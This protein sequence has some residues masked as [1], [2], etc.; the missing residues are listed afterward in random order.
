M[1]I[2]RKKNN[3]SFHSRDKKTII[4]MMMIM[5]LNRYIVITDVESQLNQ[6][7]KVIDVQCVVKHTIH[8]LW[9]IELKPK[10]KT[11]TWRNAPHLR[12][13]MK[14]K[15]S[16]FYLIHCCLFKVKAL[17]KWLIELAE[18]KNWMTTTATK[19]MMNAKNK[20]TCPQSRGQQ[21]VKL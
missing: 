10:K 4:T 14:E 18:K 16:Y 5:L 7:L 9:T 15:A 2:Q 8:D 11:E 12:A 20:R 6:H 21:K 1:K 3:E 19:Q 13:K 17:V